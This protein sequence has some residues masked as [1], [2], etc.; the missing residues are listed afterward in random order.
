[1]SKQWMGWICFIALMVVG[2]PLAAQDDSASTG[3]QIFVP[4]DRFEFESVVDGSYVTHEFTVRNTGDAPLIIE[5]VRT[6]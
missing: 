2:A 3:P 6:G 1:M 4:A 5:R